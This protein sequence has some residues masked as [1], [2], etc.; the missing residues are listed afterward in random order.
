ME[1]LRTPWGLPNLSESYLILIFEI[2]AG[3]LIL[4]LSAI[5][6]IISGLLKYATREGMSCLTPLFN[7]AEVNSSLEEVPLDIGSFI[8]KLKDPW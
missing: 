1:T 4:Y 5:G 6:S 3:V 8:N 7:A 2:K